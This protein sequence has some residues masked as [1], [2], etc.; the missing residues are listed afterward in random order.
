MLLKDKA[1]H[2]LLS[3][4]SPFIA[5]VLLQA[6]VA[7]VSLDVMTSVRAYVGGEAIWSRGQKNAVYALTLYLHS[8]DE[9]F[10][11]QYRDALAVPLGDGF[12]RAALEQ[13]FP[14]LEMAS[15]G[16][17]QGGNHPDDVPDMIW[18][19]RHF[20]DV[21]YLKAAIR[22]WAATDSM[23]I[24]LSI[25]GEA[26][27]SEMKHGL[28]ED[29]KRLDA[30]SSELHD[31]NGQL[32]VRANR[33]SEALGKVSRAIKATLTY[34]N[35]LTATALILLILWHTWR[36]V[37]QRQAFETALNEEKK[38]LAW[39]ASHDPLT[40][41]A[42]RR[43]LEAQLGAALNGFATGDTP[44][45]LVFLDLDQFKI[46]NDT[47]GHQAGDQLLREIARILK[48]ETGERDLLARLG[49]DEFGLL[50]SDCAPELAGDV[51]E[52]VRAAIERFNFTWGERSFAVT[53]SIGCTSLAHPGMSVEEALRQADLACYGAK[54]TGR[55]RVQMYH[56]DD[57]EL[58]QRVDAMSWVHRLQDALENHRFCLYAQEILP[59]REEF[60]GERYFEMLLRLKDRSGTI[61]SPAEFI[62]PAERYGLMPAIDRWVVRTAFRQLAVELGRPRILPIGQCSINLSGQT[63]GDDG[64]VAFVADELKRHAI[65]A[66]IVCFD[67]TETSAIASLDS[68]RRF[69]A[70]LRRLG[71]KFA[72]DHFGSGMSSFGYLKTMPVDFLKI[73]GAFVKG[74]LENDVDCT[75]VEMISRIGKVMGIRTVAELVAD[76]SLLTAVRQIGVDY[77]QGFAISAPRPFESAPMDQMAE[78]GKSTRE[79]A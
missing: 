29:P 24:Q 78:D 77:A 34:L 41:L 61:I 46:I 44:H 10:Y 55:N 27:K 15:V 1:S 76:P 73:D 25:F 62:A 53:G 5:V 31:L 8:G 40:E 39:Q 28:L 2:R 32:T 52:R 54:E 49:G 16:F 12:A 36:L 17:L 3:L 69:I 43:E 50:L 9:A 70:D 37:V 26:I 42:N 47:C 58:R 7:V 71:C 30:L 35:A 65:P 6:I 66:Q 18:L 23:L 38:R 33:F 56:S 63:M 79:V 59:L 22:E 19:F 20:R 48:Q 57:A 21:S 45:A 60:A 14:D 13:E 51:A 68:A 4:V 75:M 64:F 74:L 11:K 72:L 67:I